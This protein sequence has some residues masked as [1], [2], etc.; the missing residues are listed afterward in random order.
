MHGARVE[1]SVSPGH[2]APEPGPVGVAT[3]TPK[4]L[5]EN[6]RKDYVAATPAR[7][8]SPGMRRCFGSPI[9]YRSFTSVAE[10]F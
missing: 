2:L 5:R 9:K 1:I 3:T 6:K 8:A 7:R 4:K 10:P